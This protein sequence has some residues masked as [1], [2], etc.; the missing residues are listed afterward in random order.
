MLANVRTPEIRRADLR[1]AGGATDSRRAAARARGP[2]GADVPPFDEVIAYA[3][4]GAARRSPLPDG[5]YEAR[6]RSRD[7]V[8]RTLPIRVAVTIAGDAIEIDF[9]GTAPA[10]PGT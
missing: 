9:D 1:A 7:G 5:R 10:A 2:H 4:R 8:T 3:E 6:A